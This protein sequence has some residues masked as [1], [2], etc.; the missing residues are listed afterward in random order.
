MTLTINTTTYN[1]LLSEISPRVIESETDYERTLSIVEKLTF[2]KRKT[3][4]ETEIYKLLVA[5]VEAYESRHYSMSRPP[6]HEVLQ[7]ILE[8]SGTHEEDLVDTFGSIDAVSAVL[9]GETKVSDIQANILA[10]RFKVS[11]NLFTN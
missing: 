6:V 4:E 5:L 9:S 11:P 2:K 10:A 8:S 3:P 1:N 7:H